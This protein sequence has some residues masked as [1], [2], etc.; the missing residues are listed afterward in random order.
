MRFGRF[1]NNKRVRGHGRHTLSEGKAI[2]EPRRH[3]EI[4]VDDNITDTRKW[5]GKP[6]EAATFWK[7]RI[8]T[9]SEDER[10]QVEDFCPRS[11]TSDRMN[12]KKLIEHAAR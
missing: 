12:N 6:Q 10:K 4:E 1:T 5:D 8:E 7:E 3:A 11:T 2:S 9:L